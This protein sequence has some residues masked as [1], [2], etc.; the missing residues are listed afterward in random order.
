MEEVPDCIAKTQLQSHQG[1]QSCVKVQKQRIYVNVHVYVHVCKNGSNYKETTRDKK[2][3]SK[4]NV[5]A[6]YRGTPK[7]HAVS[8]WL[9]S[10]CDSLKRSRDCDKINVRLQLEAI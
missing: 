4:K 8:L 2:I 3:G 1:K 10:K 5:W 9:N 6:Q 7:E